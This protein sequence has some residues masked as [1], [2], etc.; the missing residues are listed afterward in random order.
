MGGP[1]PHPPPS[2]APGLRH[3]MDGMGWQD[4][5]SLRH[6]LVGKEDSALR[7]ALE[8]CAY[9]CMRRQPIVLSQVRPCL[10]RRSTAVGPDR[11]DRIR[12]LVAMPAST[13]ANPAPPCSAPPSWNASPR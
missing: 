3:L 13:K 12:F 4:I 6:L 9:P 1:P 5:K 10:Q 11:G 2:G 8:E 7:G